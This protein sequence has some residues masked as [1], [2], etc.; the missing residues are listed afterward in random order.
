MTPDKM[1]RF[2]AV[3]TK[4]YLALVDRDGVHNIEAIEG[5]TCIDHCKFK[6]MKNDDGLL[7]FQAAQNGKILSSKFYSQPSVHYNIEAF[8]TKMD[9]YTMF[10]LEP[11]VAV[12]TSSTSS[13]T[14]L[15]LCKD[16]WKNFKVIIIKV[17]C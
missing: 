17:K 6:V 7:A 5:D 16:N 4:K 13:N 9:A 12:T 8:K 2:L 10:E 3:E 15:A 1:V 14:H 11:W